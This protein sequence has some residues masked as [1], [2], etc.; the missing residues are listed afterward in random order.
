MARASAASAGRGG[1]ANRSRR[2][3]ICWICF[4]DA[5]PSPVIADLTAVG[6][7]S[8]TPETG[9][10]GD[11]QGDARRP[12][13]RDRRLQV[14]VGEDRLHGY[15][16]GL[17][18]FDHL[19][20]PDEQLGEPLCHRCSGSVR[21]TPASMAVGGCPPSTTPYPVADS[22]GSMPMTN[23]CLVRLGGCR[24]DADDLRWDLRGDTILAPRSIRFLSGKVTS[25]NL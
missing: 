6:A 10:G 4:L 13:N 20:Q 25:L 17:G 9:P 23:I 18:F 14:A 21:I 12:A 3:T 22:P 1:S 15:D 5:D 16:V 24:R 11:E 2:A 8:D 19:G 7:Y